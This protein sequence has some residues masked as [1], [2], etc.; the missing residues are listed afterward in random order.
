MSFEAHPTREEL[1]GFMLGD[2]GAEPTRRVL[3]HLLSDCEHCQE[4]TTLMWDVGANHTPEQPAAMEKPG[5]DAREITGRFDYDH[6][7][8]RVFDRVR[9]VNTSL[10]AERQDAQEL[11]AELLRHPL[12]RRLMLVQNSPR[13]Q[14][15]GLG[16]L[17]LQQVGGRVILEPREAKEAA[18]L[19]VAVAESLP[20][21]QYG[22]PL[23]QDLKA[24]AWAHLGN[25][26]RV[27]SDFRS[28][29]QCF[30]VAESHLARGTGD[31]LERARL[32]D[33]K[34]SLRN[35]Q[36][37]TEEAV[38]LLNRAIAIYQR[39]GQRHL[40]G[41]ALL[42]KGH[43]TMWAG[44]LET[45]IALLRQGL[46]LVDAERDPRLVVTSHHNLAYVLN[47]LG[48]HRE[49]LAIA[50]R[51][52]QLY[53]ELGDRL[54]LLRLEFLEGQIALALGRLE[55]AEGIFRE[56]RRSFGE[57]EMAYDA[58]LATLDL[59]E[60]YARQGRHAEMQALAQ[61][62]LPIFKSR[63]LQREALAALIMFQQA[64]EKNGVTLSL[65]QEVASCLQ[66]V[67]RHAAGEAAF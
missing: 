17:I 51:T 19:A 20:P 34:A 43:V 16:E 23:V 4:A 41:R 64:A 47:E 52:R 27:L 3:R 26:N 42:S 65:I 45:A 24:R 35:Y 57:K 33:L 38:S 25:A 60:V 29:E 54:S 9:R 55:Q 50:A 1:E 61:E 62:M 66:R 6:A 18:E 13:F 46:S 30:Q 40:L 44:E 5:A 28:A 21:A 31:R 37:R 12:E 56:V 32:L 11:L 58:A 39:A 63:E 14:S 8:E 15:W 2:L 48:Q 7:L 49:A 36:G 53:L 67:R 22:A 59:A 10:S